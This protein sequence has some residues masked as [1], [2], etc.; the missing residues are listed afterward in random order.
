MT[1]KIERVSSLFREEISYLLSREV[2]DPRLSGLITV[3]EVS[4]STDLRH[5]QVYVSIVGSK[6]EKLSVMSGLKSAT[7]FIRREL[8]HRLNIRRIPELNFLLD[9]SIEKGT[10]VLQLIEKTKEK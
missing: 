10:K 3:T 8:A 6:E 5:A 9:D 4:V 1:R 2:K 7:G